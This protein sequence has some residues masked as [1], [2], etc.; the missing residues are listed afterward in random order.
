MIKNNNKSCKIDNSNINV[1]SK[2]V[3]EIN[4]NDND[5][6][7]IYNL[8]AYNDTLE[9]CHNSSSKSYSSVR[10]RMEPISQENIF[11]AEV[12]ESVILKSIN[13]F[14]NSL[15]DNEKEKECDKE[16]EKEKERERERKI[17]V[18]RDRE[19]ENIDRVEKIKASPSPSPSPSASPFLCHILSLF[20][21]Q[22]T[23]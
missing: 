22:L 10:N 20:H 23:N 1:S 18:E 19:T 3:P 2:T 4:C 12:H 6:R 7:N 13:N 8:N 17:D 16:K 15:I 9:K 21:Y 14:L 11:S 5:D